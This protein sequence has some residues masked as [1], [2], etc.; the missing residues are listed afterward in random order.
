MA[1]MIAGFWLLFVNRKK[2]TPA[3]TDDVCNMIPS[4]G[5]P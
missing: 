5:E 2:D 1:I 4:Q 3:I